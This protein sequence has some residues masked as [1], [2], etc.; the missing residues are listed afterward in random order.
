MSTQ[1]NLQ[2]VS[3]VTVASGSININVSWTVL[4]PLDVRNLYT[5]AAGFTA[6]PVPTGA[7]VAIIIPPAANAVTITLKGITG[8]TGIPLSVNTPSVIACAATTAFGLTV[9]GAGIIGLEIV[10]L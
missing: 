1:L 10:F 2:S 8:D 4:T 9:G 3:S 7:T 5:F 6:V